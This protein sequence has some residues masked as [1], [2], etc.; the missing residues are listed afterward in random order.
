MIQE[1]RG[2]GRQKGELQ[3]SR[4]VTL[5]NMQK[6]IEFVA[7]YHQEKG[8]SPT[9]AEIAVGIGRKVTDAGNIQ[10]MIQQ[11]LNEGFLVSAGRNQ[12]RGLAVAKKPPRKY[13]Y[14]PD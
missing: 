7:A 8:F 14:K 12:A 10:P 11:L 5:R 1:K 2:R 3:G 6:I 4:D 13:F 9:L